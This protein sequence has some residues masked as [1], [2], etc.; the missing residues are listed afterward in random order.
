[1]NSETIDSEYVKIQSQ[2]EQV[3]QAIQ[4]SS[5]KLQA[6]ASAGDVN[7]RYYQV[8]IAG[9]AAHPERLAGCGAGQTFPANSQLPRTTLFLVE[10][11]F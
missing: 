10:R 4:A 8:P 11:P 1:M 9:S 3:G 6:A 2:V 7:A 5:Q